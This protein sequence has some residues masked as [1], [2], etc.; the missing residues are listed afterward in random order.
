MKQ[1]LGERQDPD[2]RHTA[3]KVGAV[4]ASGNRGGV[5]IH[6]GRK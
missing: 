4:T 3:G 5:G 6:S 1:E 2:E